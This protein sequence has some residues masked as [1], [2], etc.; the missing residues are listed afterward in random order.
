MR[1][2]ELTLLNVNGGSKVQFSRCTTSNPCNAKKETGNL[3]D[4]LSLIK[5]NSFTVFPPAR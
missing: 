5:I 3:K 4:L 2:N 1:V